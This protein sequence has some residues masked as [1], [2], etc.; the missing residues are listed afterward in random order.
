MR[1]K[2]TFVKIGEKSG[3]A[4]FPSWS[5]RSEVLKVLR[6]LNIQVERRDMIS[7]GFTFELT[8]TVLN[9]LAQFWWDFRI[10]QT[11]GFD[12]VRQDFRDE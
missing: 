10:C 7:G 6:F 4:T 11:Q 9:F 8:L 2:N 3:L 5:G 12:G 1:E